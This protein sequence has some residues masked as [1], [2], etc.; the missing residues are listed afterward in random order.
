[1]VSEVKTM[2]EN[3]K[4][5]NKNFTATEAWVLGCYV[6]G[7]AVII[8]KASDLVAKGALKLINKNEAFKL[9]RLTKGALTYGK[10]NDK[11]Y[12]KFQ[13]T[14]Q[15]ERCYI[16]NHPEQFIQTRLKLKNLLQYIENKLD[17][18]LASGKVDLDMVQAAK[19]YGKYRYGIMSGKILDTQDIIDVYSWIT[20]EKAYELEKEEAEKDLKEKQ[21]AAMEAM[22]RS[23]INM[24]ATDEQIDSIIKS[25]D[26]CFGNARNFK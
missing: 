4:N 11:N 5:E 9:Y 23:L 1:M 15:D 10:F 25:L 17:P 24:G 18:T 19:E 26:E 21:D 2:K 3:R 6:V 13:K 20:S 12:A 14:L 8:T 22:K 16:E 7:H